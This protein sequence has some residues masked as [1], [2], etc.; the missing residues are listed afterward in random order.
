M[1]LQITSSQWDE[2]WTIGLMSL[3]DLEELQFRDIELS[4]TRTTIVF[5][6]ACS[7]E[8]FDNLDQQARGVVPLKV[9]PSRKMVLPLDSSGSSELTPC[10]A[11]PS[12]QSILNHILENG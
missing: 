8:D 4:V 7:I 2:A 11:R 6:V 1:K 12:G 10:T 5:Q 3:V 9:K